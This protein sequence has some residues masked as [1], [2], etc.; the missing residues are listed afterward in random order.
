MTTLAPPSPIRGGYSIA[1]HEVIRDPSLSRDARL[2]YVDLDGRQGSGGPFRVR[3]ETLAAE[4]GASDKSV[5]RWLDEL[6]DRGLVVTRQTGRSLILHVHN[7]ERRSVTRD[8][9]VDPRSVTTDRSDRSPVTALQ[10]NNKR[11]I[12]NNNSNGRPSAADV[13]AD[14]YLTAIEQR[15][16]VPIRLTRSVA[17][18][19]SQIRQQG[20]SPDA[21]AVLVDAYLNTRDDIRNPGGFIRWTLQDLAAGNRP[22]QLQLPLDQPTPTPIRYDDLVTAEPCEHGDIRGAVGCALC[23]HALAGA[24]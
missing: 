14:P 18:D 4:M 16:L 10:S 21:V 15:T 22:E 1:P 11:E 9:S 20:L 19:L 23:R 8:R 3:V 24:R 5:R 13:A 2:L 17:D 7:S 6:R 12:T